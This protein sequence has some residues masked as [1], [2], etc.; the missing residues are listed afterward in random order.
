MKNFSK[1][2]KITLFLTVALVLWIVGSVT[3]SAQVK[4]VSTMLSSWWSTL[5]TIV[6]PVAN[7]VSIILG[8]IGFVKL[9][10][11]FAKFLK[12]EPTSAD[13]FLNHGGGFV[14][15]FVI[16]QLIRLVII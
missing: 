4:D 13:A 15:A 5:K 16:M 6:D 2:S 11:I 14:I 1:T 12:G 7:I 10:P 3:A 9:L 8:L